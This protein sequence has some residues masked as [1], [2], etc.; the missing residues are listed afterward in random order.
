LHQIIEFNSPILGCL[1]RFPIL[2]ELERSMFERVLAVP[3]ERKEERISGL[4]KCVFSAR[5]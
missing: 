1:E 5:G 2:R 3:V 4:F